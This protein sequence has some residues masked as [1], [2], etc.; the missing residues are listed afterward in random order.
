VNFETL[1]YEKDEGIGILKINRPKSLNA[2]NAQ[3]IKELD[4][5]LDMIESD[6]SLKVLIITGEG[7]KAF[8]AGADILELSQLDSAKADLFAR[9]GQSVF[10]RLEILKIPVIA[11]VNG[12]ALGGGTELALSCDFIYAS[13]NAKFGQPEVSLGIIPGFGGTQRLARAVGLP[14]ARELIYS[15]EQITATRALELGL[16]NRVFPL[17]KLIFEVKKTASQIALKAPL[18]VSASKEA[19][20]DGY[21]VGLDKGLGFEVDLFSDLFESQDVKEG[22]KAFLEKRKAQFKGE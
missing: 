22:T 2:L 17:D 21:D 8:V 11:A 20:N 4:E 12:F 18:A 14:M 3:V 6:R 16:V 5:F 13:E 15:G 10:R 19:I 1:I 9:H 7:E